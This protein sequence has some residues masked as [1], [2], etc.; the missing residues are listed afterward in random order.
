LPKKERK[1]AK[2]SV[3]LFVLALVC[4]ITTSEFIDM[5]QDPPIVPGPGVKE[6]LPLS[7]W[8]EELRDSPFDTDVYILQGSEKGGKLLILGGTHP[9]EPAGLVT[10]TLF[11]ENA[12]PIQGT[13]YVIPRA[14]RSAF[15]HSEPGEGT[16]QFFHIKLL[17]GSVRTFRFGSRRTN[18]IHQ[19][20]DPT[21]YRTGGMTTGGGEARNLNRAYPG[22]PRGNP[23]QKL[24]YAITQLIRKE[25][26]DLVCDLHESSPEYPVNNALVFHQKASE[27]AAMVQMFLEDSGVSIRLEESPVNLRGL[28]HRELG[29]HTNA[30]PLLF[31]V[32][33]PSQGRLRGKASEELI[34]TG[35][36]KFYLAAAK[37]GELFVDYTDKGYPLDLRVAR[38][39]AA[40]LATVEAW[41]L[42]FFD[43]PIL[44]EGVPS[45]D[46]IL[47]QG[48]GSFLR[49]TE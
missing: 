45:Y 15:T 24:A 20:P 25:D 8:L 37:R 48:I 30:Y 10:A 13:I 18:P 40:L 12:V 36:D 46:E 5:W 29:D 19:W 31:E 49:P 22:D 7:H 1:V 2:F 44:L 26:I 33:N 9:N 16:P 6:I 28:S 39:S 23:T 35:I 3:F 27:L 38:H 4:S 42:L 14:N 32:A 17:D 43:K 41:N 21:V 47:A 34:L 11:V